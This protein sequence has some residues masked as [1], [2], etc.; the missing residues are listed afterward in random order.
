ML[1]VVVLWN[2][3]VKDLDRLVLN[4]CICNVALTWLRFLSVFCTIFFCFVCLF[5]TS[6]S[7][8]FV[9]LHYGLLSKHLYPGPDACPLKRREQNQSHLRLFPQNMCCSAS[10]SR[11]QTTGCTGQTPP[12]HTAEKLER[13]LGKC[14]RPS[15]KCSVFCAHRCILKSS[16][17]QLVGGTLFRGRQVKGF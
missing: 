12:A 14:L 5:L 3:Y 9:A 6:S 11:A 8:L 1:I 13:R 10:H 2:I 7:V 4:S 16:G 17:S 15:N